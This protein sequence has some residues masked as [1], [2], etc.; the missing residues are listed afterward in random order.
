MPPAAVAGVMAATAIAKGVSDRKQ[1]K[2]ADKATAK[3]R[4]ASLRY[5]SPENYLKLLSQYRG[6]FEQEYAPHLKNIGE[7]LALGEQ[8]GMQGIDTALGRRGLSGSG[9]D[10]ALKGATRAN[11]QSNYNQAMRDFYSQAMGAARQQADITQGRQTGTSTQNPYTYT[12]RPGYGD[13]AGNALQAGVGGYAGMQTP[14]RPNYGF[15]YP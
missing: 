11:R 13:I 7:A 12:P 8:S 2:K 3:T 1:A 6:A 14:T 4:K 15:M 5:A 9:I 10:F